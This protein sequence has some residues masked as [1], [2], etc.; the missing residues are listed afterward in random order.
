M[1]AST[2]NTEVDVGKFMLDYRLGS[3]VP[4]SCL[5]KPYYE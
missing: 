2:R 3:M 1:S 5:Y 4:E